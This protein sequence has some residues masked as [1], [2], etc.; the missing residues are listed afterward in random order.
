MRLREYAS[1]NAGLTLVILLFLL[2]GIEKLEHRKDVALHI[3]RIETLQTQK[4]KYVVQLDSLGAVTA[5]QN[6]LLINASQEYD[7]LLSD[8]AELKNTKSQ[9]KVITQTRIDS[10]FVPVVSV[11]TLLIDGT[12]APIYSFQDTSSFYKIAGRVGPQ[13]A[14]IEEISFMNDITF[15]H[16]WERKNFLSKKTYFVE[17]KNT[18]PFVQI[19]GLQNYQI[20]EKKRFWE[21]GKFW[22]GVGLGTGILILTNQLQAVGFYLLKSLPFLQN[23]G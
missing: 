12:I 16:R 20:E 7:R 9:T 14:L 18:N 11:D 17:V 3:D 6:V 2:W 10:V 21:T 4:D 13:S 8:F 23:L 1:K 15:S 5:R 19:H 22:Y